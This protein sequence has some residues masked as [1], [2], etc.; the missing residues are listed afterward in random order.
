MEIMIWTMEDLEQ[1]TAKGSA[2]FFGINLQ[3]SF[4]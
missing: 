4:I 1:P 2:F 3:G